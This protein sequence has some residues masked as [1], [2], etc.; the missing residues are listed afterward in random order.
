[1]QNLQAI[2]VA[3][4]L[5]LLTA[6]AATPGG[7]SITEGRVSVAYGER[8]LKNVERMEV[9]K[10]L[11]AAEILHEYVL[12]QVERS[13]AF[14]DVKVDIVITSILIR[15]SH[16][17]KNVSRMDCDIVIYDGGKEMVRFKSGAHTSRKGRR[18]VAKM[19]AAV[20]REVYS[21]LKDG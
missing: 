11:N 5:T 16:F 10:E 21:R 15:M 12:R 3:L 17:N 4:S 19:S 1:M 2:A 14:S 8:V 9:L 7:N 20:A 18:A 13:K 6:C